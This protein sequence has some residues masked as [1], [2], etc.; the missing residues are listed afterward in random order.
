MQFNHRWA[1]LEEEPCPVPAAAGVWSIADRIGKVEFG[2]K[3]RQT[4]RRKGHSAAK[5]QPKRMENGRWKME[6]IALGHALAL[7][8]K[9]LAS[10]RELNVLQCKAEGSLSHRGAEAQRTCCGL[11]AAGCELRTPLRPSG[12]ARR[13][14]AYSRARQARNDPSRA[15]GCPPISSRR[16][17]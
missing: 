6:G 17:C 1:R 12:S 10:L 11:R 7:A 5:P 16:H 4:Q 15:G 14:L 8:Q 13:C 3:T 9:I 2:K